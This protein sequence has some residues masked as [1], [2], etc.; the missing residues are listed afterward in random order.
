MKYIKEN[1]NMDDF[2]NIRATQT[3]IKVFEKVYNDNNSNIWV[4]VQYIGVPAL[5]HI[6]VMLDELKVGYSYTSTSLYYYDDLIKMMINKF[7]TE[8]DVHILTDIHNLN[9]D[10]VEKLLK[11]M[12]ISK[13]RYIIVTLSMSDEFRDLVN[14]NTN[15]RL[16][17][18]DDKSQTLKYIKKL[19]GFN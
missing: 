10:D 14:L 2:D 4:N 12:K 15:F 5:Y 19:N 13:D 6:M 17:D 16:I 9:I 1:N 11:Y 8:Y 3:F 18:M 7:D